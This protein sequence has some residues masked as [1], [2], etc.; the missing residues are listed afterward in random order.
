M[1]Y[2]RGWFEDEKS[3]KVVCAESSG[4]S[5]SSLTSSSR[6]GWEMEIGNWELDR[7]GTA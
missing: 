1:R 2:R 5:S 7:K 4:E 6:H 3:E